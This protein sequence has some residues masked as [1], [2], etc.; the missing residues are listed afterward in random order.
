MYKR[1]QEL[2]DSEDQ[3]FTN[4]VEA[5]RIQKFEVNA[6]NKSDVEK[7]LKLILENKDEVVSITPKRGTIYEVEVR[8]FILK[9]GPKERWA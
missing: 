1:H 4:M 2:P 5:F 6:K 7:A 9:D 8:I 3:G